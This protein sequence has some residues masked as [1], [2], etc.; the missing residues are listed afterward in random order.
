MSS[1]T[2][3]TLST[4]DQQPFSQQDVQLDDI[5]LSTLRS[6]SSLCYE[7]RQSI[8]YPALERIKIGPPKAG[9]LGPIIRDYSSRFATIA[10]QC[11]CQQIFIR[12]SH[13]PGVHL[14]QTRLNELQQT[15]EAG[16]DDTSTG[17][18]QRVHVLEK[19]NYE[20]GKVSGVV[21]T[22]IEQHEYHLKNIRLKK[23]IA[24]FKQPFRQ[25]GQFSCP[26]LL[27]PV[28]RSQLSTA[29]R[30]IQP[31]LPGTQFGTRLSGM[32]ASI[33]QQPSPLGSSGK[34][35]PP[36]ITKL[37]RTTAIPPWPPGMNRSWSC[38]Q[39]SLGSRVQW[40]FGNGSGGPGMVV[41]PPGPPNFFNSY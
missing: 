20:N 3:T 7:F 40:Q 11:D 30:Q 16:F 31:P 24:V 27:V 26:K 25:L 8:S 29:L 4:N 33:P 13:L 10:D 12:Y 17:Y 22:I 35:F 28:L 19:L 2:A 6:L 39:N 36:F 18:A 21:D 5:S 15:L 1:P 9:H 32:Q 41:Q 14:L 38:F 23:A 34:G 37:N